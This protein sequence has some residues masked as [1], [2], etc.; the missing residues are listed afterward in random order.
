MSDLPTNNLQD[1]DPCTQRWTKFIQR[2][3]N[4]LNMSESI[5][6]GEAVVVMRQAPQEFSMILKQESA[7]HLAHV[8]LLLVVATPRRPGMSDQ[9]LQTF[10]SIVKSLLNFAATVLFTGHPIHRML[11]SLAKWEIEDM[12]NFAQN[13]HHTRNLAPFY[14]LS[15]LGYSML[16]QE[17]RPTRSDNFTTP[18]IWNKM[19]FRECY[20]LLAPEG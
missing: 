12:E 13:H 3:S 9:E 19:S 20:T 7:N 16:S 1:M 4:A 6:L 11:R 8:H 5:H 18:L 17:V 15:V 2:L 14:P 10:L